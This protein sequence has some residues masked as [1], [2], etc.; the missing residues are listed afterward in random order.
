ML[1]VNIFRKNIYP[2]EPPL[3]GSAKAWH[4]VVVN[5]VPDYGGEDDSVGTTVVTSMHEVGACCILVEV[6]GVRQRVVRGEPVF[7]L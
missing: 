4:T 7:V 6:P 1:T 2:I 5:K 3:D